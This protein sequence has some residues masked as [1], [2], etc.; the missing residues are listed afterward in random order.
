MKSLFVWFEV[1]WVLTLLCFNKEF[2][3]E[4]EEEQEVEKWWAEQWK[5]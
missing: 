5:N 1:I 4:V 3:A 2:W